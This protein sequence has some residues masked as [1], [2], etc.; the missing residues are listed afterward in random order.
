M[1]SFWRSSLAE[2]SSCHDGSIATT[3][4][5][6]MLTLKLKH[7]SADFPDLGKPVEAPQLEQ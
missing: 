1:Q 6:P 5:N 2:P 3:V 7:Q 4:T